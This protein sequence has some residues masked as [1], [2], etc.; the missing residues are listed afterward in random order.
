MHNLLSESAQAYWPKFLN[1]SIGYGGENIYGRPPWAP[2]PEIVSSG[3]P[4]RKFVISLDYNL[5]SLSTTTDTWTALK[6]IFDLFHYPAPAVR[7]VQGKSPV[8]KPFLLN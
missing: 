7:F 1:L 2:G 6:H 8:F 3:T 5:S 4:A